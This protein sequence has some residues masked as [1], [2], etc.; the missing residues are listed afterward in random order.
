MAALITPAEMINEDKFYYVPVRSDMPR[1]IARLTGVID[2]ATVDFC[3]NFKIS[4]AFVD[5]I[6]KLEALRYWTYAVWQQSQRLKKTQAGTAVDPK[7]IKGEP[8]YD[9]QKEADC[10]NAAINIMN[11]FLD[12]KFPLILPFF[13][14]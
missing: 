1:D 9:V 2:L 11:K 4:E 8:V 12:E 13:N 5:N 6:E 7:L 14:Y 10:R 3:S